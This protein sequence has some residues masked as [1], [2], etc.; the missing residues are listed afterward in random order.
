MELPEWVNIAELVIAGI[1]IYTWQSG[2]Q[3][4]IWFIGITGIV[5]LI[6]FMIDIIGH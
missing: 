5:L 2:I 1:F 6:D 3:L 4:P